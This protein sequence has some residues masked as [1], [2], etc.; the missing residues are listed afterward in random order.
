MANSTMTPPLPPHKITREIPLSV[1]GWNI[2]VVDDTPDNVTVIRSVLNY[3]GAIVHTARNGREGLAILE[4]I[5]PNLILADIRMPEVDGYEI[6]EIIRGNPA[7]TNIPTIAVTAYAIDGDKERIVSAG[8]DG[9]ISKPFNVMTLVKD[10]G[11]ILNRIPS[12]R[13]TL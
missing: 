8:F 6:I 5:C 9:Y 10:I 2:L 13:S 7:Y 1:E 11:R 12:S 3:H 4:K